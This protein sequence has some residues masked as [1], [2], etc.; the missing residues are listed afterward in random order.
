MLPNAGTMSI[1][2]NTTKSFNP[3]VVCFN[4]FLGFCGGTSISIAVTA[5]EVDGGGQDDVGTNNSSLIDLV[6]DP[7]E[8]K[9]VILVVTIPELGGDE[10]N[11]AG[12]EAILTFYFRVTGT[13]P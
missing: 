11:S 12:D 1:P 4:A 5:T 10:A 2:H 6:C 13:C 7:P 9:P 8:S 3:G